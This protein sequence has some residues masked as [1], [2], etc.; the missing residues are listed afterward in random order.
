VLKV[1]KAGTRVRQIWDRIPYASYSISYINTGIGVCFPS[2]SVSIFYRSSSG[3]L[4][5]FQ[6]ISGCFPEELPKNFRRTPKELP[7]LHRR[8]IEGISKEYGEDMEGYYLRH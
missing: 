6:G 2:T 5:D 3:I 1:S 8:N 4:R 7:K